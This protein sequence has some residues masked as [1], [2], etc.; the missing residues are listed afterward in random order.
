MPALEDEAAEIRPAHQRR[1]AGGVTPASAQAFGPTG[2]GSGDN[3]RVAALAIDDSSATAWQ[4]SWYRSAHFG[5]L[6][7]GTA[8]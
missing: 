5:N 2:Y 4:T 7:D 1:H 8:C 3:S 6:Q